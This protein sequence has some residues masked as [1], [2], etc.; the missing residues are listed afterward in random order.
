MV[1]RPGSARGEGDRCGSRGS[2]SVIVDEIVGSGTRGG[3]H[4]RADSSAGNARW[5]GAGVIERQRVVGVRGNTGAGDDPDRWA[6]GRGE[7]WGA[8]GHEPIPAF[9]VGGGRCN[10]R[11]RGVLQRHHDARNTFLIGILDAIVVGIE[12]HDVANLEWSQV[13]QGLNVS[14]AVCFGKS[15][16]IG[17][18]LEGHKVMGRSVELFLRAVLGVVPAK[19]ALSSCR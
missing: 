18:E 11:S 19:P 15:A 4:P 3:E 6:C 8:C 16:L 10:D 2:G 14:E 9:G 7:I 13:T 1:V 5:V 17:F 12:P